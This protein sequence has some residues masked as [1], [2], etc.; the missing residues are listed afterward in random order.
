MGRRTL[1]F[2]SQFPLP[3]HPALSPR[4]REPIIASKGSLEPRILARHVQISVRHAWEPYASNSLGP[5]LKMAACMPVPCCPCWRDRPFGDFPS[6]VTDPL[7]MPN[8][9]TNADKRETISV[10]LTDTFNHFLRSFSS[11]TLGF[12]YLS[13]HSCECLCQGY[14]YT[15][16]NGRRKPNEK[17]WQIV[18][19]WVEIKI[20]AGVVLTRG[21]LGFN[22]VK[23]CFVSTEN[24]PGFQ[25]PISS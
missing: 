10:R 23:G 25:M 2:K 9:Y 3:V 5:S 4:A 19:T 12:R 18:M 16:D 11:G 21:A 1:H 14:V 17:V 24:K 20:S 6:I 15:E 7:N 8:M 22:D 13:R